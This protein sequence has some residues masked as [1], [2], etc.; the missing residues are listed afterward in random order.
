MQYVNEMSNYNRLS[1]L[2][3]DILIK[4]TLTIT[5]TESYDRVFIQYT[6]LKLKQDSFTFQTT[7]KIYKKSQKAK[8]QTTATLKST[9]KILIK[10]KEDVRELCF[11]LPYLLIV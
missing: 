5:V 4:S 11:F 1:L 7:K 8:Q 10:L 9:T 6:S 2:L 3:S